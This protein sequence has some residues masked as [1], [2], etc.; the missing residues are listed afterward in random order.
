MWRGFLKTLVLIGCVSLASVFAS[1]QEVVHA[2]SGTVSN[3]NLSAKTI[4][5]NTDDG[6]EGTFK[7]MTDPKTRVEFDKTLRADATDA[8][9]FKTKGTRVIVYYFGYS[10]VR[11]AVALRDLGP[12]PFTKSSGTI[13][14]VEKG[15]RTF[16][17]KDP[18][19]TVDS[20]K[21]T[22]ST[23]A[24]TGSGAVDGLKFEPEK[25]D[26]VQVISTGVNGNATALFVNAM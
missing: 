24:D 18:T 8:E 17:I 10:E 5:V 2:L 23:V 12:G 19:G 14:K 16:T 6:S 26:Q 25:G 15:E 4:T 21:M 9:A 1:A 7:A 3:V 22:R 13:I 20:F 11:T